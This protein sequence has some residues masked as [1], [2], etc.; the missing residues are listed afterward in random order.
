MLG[1]SSDRWVLAR[2]VDPVAYDW[3]CVVETAP[4]LSTSAAYQTGRRDDLRAG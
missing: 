1:L 4:R 3:R 2:T